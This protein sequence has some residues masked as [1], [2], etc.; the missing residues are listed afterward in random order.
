MSANNRLDRQERIPNW[1]QSKL[2]EAVVAIV[3]DETL[4]NYVAAGL[5]GLGIGTLKIFGN[6]KASQVKSGEFLNLGLI[7]EPKVNGLEEMISL[8]MPM[9]TVK[10]VEWEFI[11]ESDTTIL[12]KPSVIVNTSNDPRTSYYL[13]VYADQEKIAL[14][15]SYSS[16]FKGKLMIFDPTLDKLIYEKVFDLKLGREVTKITNLGHYMSEK[17]K[18]L[19]QDSVTSSVVA[20]LVVDQVRKAVMPIEAGEALT[21][22]T[23]NY[24]LLSASRVSHNDDEK[25]YDVVK[26]KKA[27]IVGAGS[28]GNFV[29][30]G[31]ALKGIEELL[32]IDD[33]TVEDA[34]LNRQIVFCL[35]EKIIG[36]PVVGKSKSEALSAVLRKLNPKIKID[37]VKGKFDADFKY[38]NRTYDVIF[39]CVDK[40]ISRESIHQYSLKTKIP[41]ISGGTDFKSGR[42]NVVVPGKTYCFD[43]QINVI[44]AASKQREREANSCIAEP[45]P[46]VITSNM[47]IA[48]MMVAEYT[49]MFGVERETGKATE[50]LFGTIEFHSGKDNILNFTP[51]GKGSCDC[52]DPKVT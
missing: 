38:K 33:D 15:N 12:R 22:Q 27:V 31:L 11:N 30:L 21:R 32:I 3:G 2:N 42:L 36:E 18:G 9:G 8:I 23:I 44:S 5:A 47:N 6:Q 13:T 52:Y 34:N 19:E 25:E 1:K 49:K 14:I 29:A 16:E 43:H 24:N 50:P 45:D 10:G 41:I 51:S 40:F 46:S 37:Y 48:S 39:D 4:S 7:R 20:S 28:L 26:N 17:F 35:Y